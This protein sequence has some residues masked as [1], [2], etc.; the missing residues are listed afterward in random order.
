MR[1]FKTRWFA[2]FAHQH[3]IADLNLIEAIGRAEQGQIAANLGGYVIKQRLAGR[4][5]GKSGGYRAVVIFRFDD[6]AFF[7]YGFPKNERSNVRQ[8]E[9]DGFRMLGKELLGYSAEQLAAALAAKALIEVKI[10][11]KN[12]QD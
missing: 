8:D 12:L 4:N 5:E 6:R 2:R 1:I 11:E 7:I 9:L 10:N 3:E